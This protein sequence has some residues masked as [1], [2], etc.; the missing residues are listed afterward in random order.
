[1]SITGNGEYMSNDMREKTHEPVQPEDTETKFSFLKEEFFSI[2]GY[3]IRPSLNTIIEM[4]DM[5]TD[6]RDHEKT[7]GFILKANNE[8]KRLLTLIND[9]LDINNIEENKF[10]LS[11]SDF[12][13]EDMLSNIS[14]VINSRVEARNQRL[15]ISVDHDVPE[16][17]YGDE[18]RLM[19]VIINLL[20][21]AVNFSSKNEKINLN[22]EK[23]EEKGEFVV[24]RI[25]I[26]NTGINILNNQQKKLFSSFEETYG[27]EKSGKM[28]PGL[29]ISKKIIE[30]MDGK[31]WIES[32]L[33]KSEL[34]IFT[35]KLKIGNEK[36]VIDHHNVN[37]DHTFNFSGKTILAVDDN[38]INREVLAAVLE[39][40]NVNIDFARDGKTAFLMFKENQDKYNLILM[41]VHMPEMNGFEATREIRSLNTVQ[42]VEVPIIAMTASVFKEEITKCLGAGMNDHVGKPID[43][44]VLYIT[45]KKHILIKSNTIIRKVDSGIKWDDSLL[46]GNEQLDDQNRQLFEH[47]NSL[48]RACDEGMSTVKLKNTLDFLESY[49]VQHFKDEEAL[50][51]K[52]KY[53]HY[54]RHKKMHDDFKLTVA[55]FEKRFSNTG[56]SSELSK[57]VNKILVKWLIDHIMYEDKKVGVHLRGGN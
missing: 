20:I 11:F 29:V 30:L 19:Q 18:S 54:E 48:V 45:I 27:G 25:E 38:E 5:A 39:K 24:L 35:V 22:I 57:D 33:D 15:I 14:T 32:G 53:P 43:P 4:L 55:N 1:M 17:I 28:D 46:L 7:H 36:N 3:E 40:T 2:I 9:I 52:N 49:S 23:M 13:L 41:D 12:D 31:M 21:Y 10:L 51:V 56:S 47:V 16:F 26:V 42:S 8:S 50:Q 6:A 34:F 37:L 44:D